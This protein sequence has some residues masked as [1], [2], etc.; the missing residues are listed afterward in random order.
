MYYSEEVTMCPRKYE[1]VEID[2][3]IKKLLREG[4]KKAGS[5][6]RLAKILG[7]STPSNIIAQFLSAPKYKRF[8]IVSKLDRL[9]EFLGKNNV[10]T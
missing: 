10:N 4:I 2:D 8:I 3:D 1:H 5:Q 7:Y 6:N 9:R